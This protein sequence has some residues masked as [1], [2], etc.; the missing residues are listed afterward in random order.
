MFRCLCVE[1]FK[2]N[3][4]AKFHAYWSINNEV[5]MHDGEGFKKA[6]VK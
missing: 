5:M 6:H 2:F 1:H 4:F 3:P